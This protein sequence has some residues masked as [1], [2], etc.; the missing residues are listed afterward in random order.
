MTVYFNIRENYQFT[1]LYIRV[2]NFYIK[3]ALLLFDKSY[4]FARTYLKPFEHSY[5]KLASK[6]R[7]PKNDRMEVINE[8]DQMSNAKTSKLSDSASDEGFNSGNQSPEPE[9][10][11]R[12]RRRNNRDESKK[13]RRN[14]KNNNPITKI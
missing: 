3:I 8:D 10:R 2:L 12:E 9:E 7:R 1:A 14:H 11:K 5:P 4:I 6:A 13:R